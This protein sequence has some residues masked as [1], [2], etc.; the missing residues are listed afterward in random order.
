MNRRS[1]SLFSLNCMTV[2][3]L[4]LLMAMAVVWAR[5]YIRTDR[6]YFWTETFLTCA[7]THRGDV[8]FSLRPLGRPSGGPRI[9]HVIDDQ[10]LDPDW[11]NRF[12]GYTVDDNFNYFR[13]GGGGFGYFKW[14]D[15]SDPEW[16]VTLPMW[17]FCA[18]SAVIPMGWSIGHVRRRWR[19]ETGRCLA[20]GYDLRETPYRCPE[21]GITIA[22]KRE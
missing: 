12:K 22:N 19:R 6:L 18:I 21:C 3:S 2:F 11:W 20:C 1:F 16:D 8:V 9:K 15:R 14:K 17:F 7:E 5:T 4:L 10:A 13:W